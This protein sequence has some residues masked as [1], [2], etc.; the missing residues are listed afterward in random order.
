MYQVFPLKYAGFFL[1]TPSVFRERNPVFFP[2]FS[3]KKL[4]EN[5]GVSPLK[6]ASKLYST[7]FLRLF[8]LETFT[9]PTPPCPGYPLSPSQ[10][11]LS[12]PARQCSA[13]LAPFGLLLP[14]PVRHLQ[15]PERRLLGNPHCVPLFFQYFRPY[16]TGELE[17]GPPVR[18]QVHQN[19]ESR[20]FI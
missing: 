18:L 13:L 10:P 3:P 4:G 16:R 12:I 14:S 9:S 5:K 6:I 17:S 19:S 2:F 20:M 7:L 8:Y 11:S 15:H 1:A